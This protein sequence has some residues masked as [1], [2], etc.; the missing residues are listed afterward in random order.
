M[1]ILKYFPGT[2][3]P[4]QAL[5]LQDLEKNWDTSD[6]HVLQLPVAFGKTKV[7]QC[8]QRW[9]HAVKKQK[10]HLSVP[11][12]M[13]VA[14][15]RQDNPRLCTLEKKD[16]YR[17]TSMRP[18][19]VMPDASCGSRHY[20]QGSHCAECPYVAAIRAAHGMPWSASNY[21]TALAHK[22]HKPVMLFDEAHLLLSMIKEM[23]GTRIWLHQLGRDVAEGLRGLQTY[24]DLHQYLDKH[25]EVV[26]LSQGL[27]QIKEDLELGGKRWLVSREDELY[28]GQLRE[29]LALL[30]LDTSSSRKAQHLWP[31]KKVQKIVLMSATLSESDVEQMALSGKRVKF[32]T[33]PSPIDAGRRRWIY[34]GDKVGSM[35]AKLQQQNLGRCV[36]ALAALSLEGQG[37]GLI[38]AT[39]GLAEKIYPLL[40]AQLLGRVEVFTHTAATKMKQYEAWRAYVG[41]A[42]FIASGFH[43]GIDLLGEQFAWQA[44][45]KVPFPSLE[46]PAL[47]WLAEEEPERY[48]WITARELLQAYG[49]ICRGPS[50]VGVTHILDAAFKRFYTTNKELFPGWFQEAG[51]I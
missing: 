11:N 1:S 4:G 6:V 2:P 21:H 26:K 51:Q 46:D 50:D 7:A 22:L 38:H 20:A 24:E 31:S 39:Y 44:I 48:G 5:V 34:G 25:P 42:V 14:Q 45:T 33:G 3:R 13:L 35:S 36:G 16:S 47:R 10:S 8:I 28:H 19:A 32:Y 9:A 27:K 17:C 49:R 40:R 23:E 37:K 30:P 15:L 29:C 18:E 43:E 12:N 41:P